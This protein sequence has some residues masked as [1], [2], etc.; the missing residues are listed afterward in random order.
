MDPSLVERHWNDL[1]NLSRLRAK[2][3]FSRLATT[4]PPQSPVAWSTFITGLDP[5]EHGIFDF[6]HRDP[7]TLAPYLST[8][9]TE[10]PRLTMT[11]G[12]YLLPLERSHVISLRKG[13]AFWQILA[14]HKIP[15]AILRIPA[16]YP[17]VQAG[18][19]IAGMGTPDLR[20][21]LGTFSFYT[22]DPDE[23]TRAVSGGAIN[24][25]SLRDGHVSLKIEGPPDSL[26]KDH[27]VSEAELLVDVDPERPLARLKLGS[28]VAI[29]RQGEWSDWMVADFELL[30]HVANVRGMIR[31]YAKQLHPQFELYA[32]P[33]NIDPAAPA[34]PISAPASFSRAIAEEIGP[35]FTLGIPEDTSAFRQGVFD[36]RDFLSQSRLVLED[37]ER[38]FQYS[39]DHFTGGFLFF[40]FSSVDQNSHML[41]GKYN[42]NLLNVYRAIDGCI[43]EAARRFPQT[44]LM[45]MSDH[46][47][48][49]FERAV[50]LNTWLHENGYLALKSTGLGGTAATL[51]DIDW[52]HTKAYALGLNG[53]YLNMAGRER[54]GIV[55]DGAERRALLE[56]LENQLCAFRDPQSGRVVFE[57]VTPARPAAG[58]SAAGNA[59]VAP[60][61]IA[62]Y[63]RG[64]RASW[65]TAL[66]ETPKDVIEENTDAWIADHCINSADVPG[67]LFTSTPARL[68]DPSLKDLAPSILS[69]YGIPKPAAMSGRNIF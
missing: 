36:L 68:P 32:S 7:A 21:T 22:D 25:V 16:N 62:G 9:R 4:T 43:G 53:L 55:H 63:A 42:A 8:D 67:V 2:G 66:G 33:V 31:V 3:S 5:A 59:H 46:G 47:F 49:S 12:P 60:D 40:Y 14:R 29:V 50:N 35:Y 1:P 65:Q 19:E 15:A 69:L 34:L 41:W 13:E 48:S 6:V 44:E 26:R 11:L 52:P 45:V 56:A 54:H 20:G 61:L 10:E 18:N 28:D 24:R 57:A 64:Y 17:P 30:P 39:L 51:E 58:N 37:E 38:L 27:R 23:I